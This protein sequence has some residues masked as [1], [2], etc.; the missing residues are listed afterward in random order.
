MLPG[1]CGGEGDPGVAKSSRGVGEGVIE[2][3]VCNPGCRVDPRVWGREDPKVCVCGR[4]VIQGLKERSIQ[5]CGGGGYPGVVRDEVIPV[6][7]GGNPEVSKTSFLTV[8]RRED[9]KTMLDFIYASCTDQHIWPEGC[10]FAF[11]ITCV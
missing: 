8:P 7:G 9:F 11:L 6:C 5:G 3:V 1:V 4:G 10:D 2:G